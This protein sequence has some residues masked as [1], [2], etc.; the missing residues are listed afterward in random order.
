M[1]DTSTDKE[2]H[3]IKEEIIT[4]EIEIE[5]IEDQEEITKEEKD[6]DNI[7]E[8]NTIITAIRIRIR[9][10][11]ES[12]MVVKIEEVSRESLLIKSDLNLLL[13]LNYFYHKQCIN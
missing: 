3:S 6:Q 4:R 8:R 1:K 12:S 7:K 11:R 2:T 10:I 9:I 5:I 13:T